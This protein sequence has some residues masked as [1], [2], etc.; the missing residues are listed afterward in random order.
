[1]SGNKMPDFSLADRAILT[2]HGYHCV[3]KVPRGLRPS[4]DPTLTACGTAAFALEPWKIMD[5]RWCGSPSIRISRLRFSDVLRL[6]VLL[7]PVRC[8]ACEQRYFVSAFTA[9]KLHAAEKAR[10]IERR[11]RES[12]S[13]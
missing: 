5:C 1:M 11:R 10:R 2:Y 9:F 8:R 13:G 7:Y 4:Y 3:T 12:T 6:V